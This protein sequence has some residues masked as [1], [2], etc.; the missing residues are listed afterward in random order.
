MQEKFPQRLIMRFF[1]SMEER[2]HRIVE[3][4]I[5]IHLHPTDVDPS[6]DLLQRVPTRFAEHILG[7][8]DVDEG[9]AMGQGVEAKEASLFDRSKVFIQLRQLLDVYPQRNNTS[10]FGCLALRPALPA[11]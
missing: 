4:I 3:F 11:I 9:H 2:R 10:P 8:K 5:G 1:V 7:E 6:L